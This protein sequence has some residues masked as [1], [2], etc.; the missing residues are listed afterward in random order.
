RYKKYLHGVVINKFRGDPTLLAPGIRQIEELTGVPVLGVLP[1]L[2]DLQIEEEDSLGLE[3]TKNGAIKPVLDV[4]VIRLPRISN[5][6]DFL[7]IENDE[8]IELRY[9]KSVSEIGNPD[10]VII[11]G[12]KNTRSDLQWLWERGLAEIISG[13]AA[14][15][16][17]VCGICGGYQMLGE[18]V[19]DPQGVEGEKGVS[20]GLAMLPLQTVLAPQK[21]LA[22]V[23]GRLTGT[24]PFVAEPVEFQGYEIH[25]GVTSVTETD[26]GN[27]N[28]RAMLTIR[29][30]QGQKVDEPGGWISKENS[31]FGCYV[32]GLF[33]APGV[34]QSLWQWLC[35]RNGKENTRIVINHA[36]SQLAFDRLADNME[37]YLSSDFFDCLL[38]QCAKP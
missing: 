19:A 4:V 28:H 15:G 32:H 5:F 37:K 2:H 20:R 26:N 38:D 9:V 10:L 35:A 36:G 18:Q 24:M 6:T 11:P 13:M 29:E 1:Y 7:A 3:K 22:Q 23:R 30:R 33:D 16:T 25:A 8:G 31:V 17:P 12:T 34:R 27:D 21:T 14:E